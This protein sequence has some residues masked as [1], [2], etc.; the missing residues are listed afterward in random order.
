MESFIER[1][2]RHIEEN[3]RDSMHELA[4]VFPNRRAGNF[5]KRTLAARSAQPIWA[6]QTFS[7]EEFMVKLSGMELLDNLSALFKLYSVYKSCESSDP[8]PFEKFLTWGPT[9]V[10]DFNEIDLFQVDAKQILS[11]LYDV[12]K[13]KQWNLGQSEPTEIQLKYLEFWSKLPNWYNAYTQTLLQEGAGYQGLLFREVA[14]KKES[15]AANLGYKKVL[16]AG[17][18]ALNTCEVELF[19]YLIDSGKAEIIWDLDTYYT[20]DLLQEAGFN[21]RK[22]AQTPLVKKATKPLEG[23]YLSSLPRTITI[24]GVPMQTAQA[25]TMQMLLEELSNE[26]T[27]GIETAVVLGDEELIYPSLSA[28]PKQIG[29]FNATLGL[30]YKST[31]AYSFLLLLLELMEHHLLHKHIPNRPLLDATMHPYTEF[32]LGKD[33]I[34]AIQ[35]LLKEKRIKH[36]FT[37]DELLSE[38]PPEA[39]EKLEQ[40]L[41]PELTIHEGSNLIQSVFDRILREVNPVLEEEEEDLSAGENLLSQ[42]LYFSKQI[43]AKLS[44]FV[45]LLPP[46]ESGFKALEKILLLL[47]GKE[48]IPLIGEPLKGLQVMGM[49]ETRNLDFKNVFILGFNEGKIPSAEN[50]STFISNETR[51]HFKLPLQHDRDAVFAYHF[52]RLMQRAEKVWLIYDADEEQTE[53]SRFLLQVEKEWAKINSQL[54]VVRRNPFF[55]PGAAREPEIHIKK[56]E[57]HLAW[58]RSKAQDKGFSPSAL[59]IFRNCSLQ[60]YLNY[61]GKIEGE[62]QEDDMLGADLFGSIIHEVLEELFIPLLGATLTPKLIDELLTKYPPVLEQKFEEKTHIASKDAGRYSIDLEIAG[63]YVQK[64]LQALKSKMGNNT[65]VQAL[66]KPMSV[67]F[68]L[69]SGE[70]VKVSGTTDRVELKGNTY[71]I[72]DFKTGKIDLSNVTVKDWEDL[73]SNPDKNK[74]FQLISYAWMFHKSEGVPIEDIYPAFISTRDLD[75]WMV[76]LKLDNS[77]GNNSGILD[78][79][80]LRE[81]ESVLCTLLSNLMDINQGFEQTQESKTCEYCGF[82]KFCSR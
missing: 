34:H 1:V 14:K 79:A 81:F 65:I 16:L 68:E 75:S 17:F 49:L 59:N 5:L 23:D 55:L 66:E 53:P 80:S 32:W 3:Y 51:F 7:T 10:K 20:R 58:L 77:F 69:A 39:T 25:R 28:I 67:L 35:K 76:G 43:V 38:L 61:L 30:P 78:I 19:S 74:A 64:Y 52:Y 27:I 56:T 22:L 26:E 29:N 62:S 54:K 73:L 82:K 71:Q 45:G 33:L 48:S 72:L 9:L 8:E 12:E 18:N 60:F 70:K 50:T 44:A 15:I 11:Y 21:F 6:P 13:L 47:A 4:L 63:T 36:G 24:A 57:A 2:A 41:N 46:S 40:F 42:E 31:K 37:K